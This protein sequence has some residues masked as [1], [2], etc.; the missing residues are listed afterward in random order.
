[1]VKLTAHDLLFILKQIKIAE[2]HAAGGDLKTLIEDAA[3]A[4]GATGTA[5]LQAHLLPYGLRTVDGTY[6]NLF[7]GR[8]AWG[9]ADRP[10]V[11]LGP[12]NWVTESDDTIVFG[13]GSPGQVVFTDGNYSQLG[14]PPAA[15]QGLGG[16]TLVDADPRIISNLIVD[17]TSNN[18]A[19]IMVYRS[20][21]ADGKNATRTEM[22]DG[23]GNV[24]THT[25][26][27]L[28]PTGEVLANVG[29][30]RRPR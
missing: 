22:R 30:G 9:A 24:V 17:Q 16:G 11:Q 21:L 4:A 14:P 15:S 6:N 12:R 28:S 27:V 19:A 2:A 23:D 18:P 26:Q 5:N 7:N 13:A 3:K 29:A 1:M 25:K 10:F 8:E 20:M